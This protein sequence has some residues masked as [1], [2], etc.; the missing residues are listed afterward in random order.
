MFE[1][2]E[3]YKLGVPHIDAQHEKLFEIGNRAYQ[4][5]KD[6]F[7]SD[8]YDKIVAIINELSEYTVIHFRDEEAYM[9]SINYK[10]LFTQKMEH[11]DFIKTVSEI[12]FNKMD[13]NQDEYLMGILDFVAKW[14]AG[15]IIEKDLLIVAK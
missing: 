2:K 3:E 6:S 11:A 13:D 12:D 10:K 4:L 7:S 14:L 8:K 5:L 1:M 9:E 15:H